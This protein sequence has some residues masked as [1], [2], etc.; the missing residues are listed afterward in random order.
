MKHRTAIR[1]LSVL[2]VCLWLTT[3]LTTVTG[4]SQPDGIVSVPPSQGRYVESKLGYMVPFKQRIPETK[5]EFEMIPIDGVPKDDGSNSA[6]FWM[7]KFEVTLRE[8]REFAKLGVVLRQLSRRQVTGTDEVDA[9]TAPTDIYDTIGFFQGVE[10]LQCPAFSMTLYS[11]KQYSK[12]L[13]LTVDRPYRLPTEAEWEHACSA[14][15]AKSLPESTQAP[16]QF[17]VFNKPIGELEKVGSKKPNNW[18][19]HD[20]YGN[21]SEWVIT[22]PPKVAASQSINGFVPAWISK[23]GCA[24]SSIEQLTTNNR[25][26]ATQEYWDIDPDCPVSCSWLGTYDP[27]IRIGFRLVCELG[28]LDKQAMRTYW[29]CETDE[30]REW[31]KLKIDSGRAASARVDTKLP[32][33]SAEKMSSENVWKEVRLKD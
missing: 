23:G 27:N 15:G 14:G 21:V 19:L 24:A 32:K 26:Q 4:Q 22:E 18:G 9:V 12:W 1:Q 17:A 30:M 25:A 6:P 8:Y 3:C 20:M 28:E 33:E 16:E 31:V 13:S 10:S 2:W 7:G 5:I 11:A 29:D